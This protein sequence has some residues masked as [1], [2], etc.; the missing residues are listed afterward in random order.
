MEVFLSLNM[1][2]RKKKEI[3]R[4]AMIEKEIIC[5]MGLFNKVNDFKV[6]ATA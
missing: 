5:S 4:P 1:A 3:T 6:L 2:K